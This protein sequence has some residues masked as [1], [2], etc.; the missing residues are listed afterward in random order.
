MA[1]GPILGMAN[2]AILY[3][4]THA[5]TKHNANESVPNPSMVSSLT[6]GLHP[7]PILDDWTNGDRLSVQNETVRFRQ[8]CDRSSILPRVPVGS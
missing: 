2:A 6:L 4:D 7:S 5:G 3:P 1:G 8:L